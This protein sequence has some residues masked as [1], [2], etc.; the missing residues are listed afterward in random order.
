M[1]HARALVTLGDPKLQVKI[2]KRYSNKVI[3]YAK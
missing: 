2:L 3:P 1:G